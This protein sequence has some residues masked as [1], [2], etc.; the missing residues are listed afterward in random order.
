MR[1]LVIVHEMRL[2]LILAG[3]AARGMS[4]MKLSVRLLDF[5][6]NH[7]PFFEVSSMDEYRFR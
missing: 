5:I 7:L 4:L 6:N 1:F 3:P 2:K